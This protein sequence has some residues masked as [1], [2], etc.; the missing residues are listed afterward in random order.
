MAVWF[1]LGGCT[2]PVQLAGFIN[3]SFASEFHAMLSAFKVMGAPA[4]VLRLIVSV[5]DVCARVFKLPGLS[6]NNAPL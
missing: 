4:A 1:Q 3:F 2:V 6:V 5:V